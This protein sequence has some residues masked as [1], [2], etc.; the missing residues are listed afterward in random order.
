MT[1][2][3]EYTDWERQEWLRW[4]SSCDR[5]PLSVSAGPHADRR[6][7][8]VGEVVRHIFLAEKRYVDRLSARPITETATLPTHDLQVLFR[9]G[10]QSR[11][12]LK[13][14]ISSLNL[15]QW[16]LPREFTLMNRAFKA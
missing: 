12:D 1:E 15:E 16:D 13:E 4:M 3:L 6:F 9:F 11:I 2:L 7:T 10:E 5:N 8:T 14:Y